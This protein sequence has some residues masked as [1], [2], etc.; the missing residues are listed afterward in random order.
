MG[1]L[2]TCVP[3]CVCLSA[4]GKCRH[5]TAYRS[6]LPLQSHY[7]RKKSSTRPINESKIRTKRDAGSQERCLFGNIDVIPDIEALL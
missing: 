6:L 5:V 7:H 4:D 3:L 1:K 2:Q